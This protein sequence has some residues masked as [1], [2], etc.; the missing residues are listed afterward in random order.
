MPSSVLPAE[1]ANAELL[2]LLCPDLLV[3][4]SEPERRAVYWDISWGRY[5]ALDKKLG[6]N[7]PS[8]R[9]YYLNGEL[10]IM[11]T[12]KRHELLKKLIAGLLEIFFDHAGIEVVP[13]GQATMQEELKAA[14]AEPDESWSIGQEKQYADLVLEIALSS[15]GIPKLGIYQRFAI[16]EVWFRRRDHLEIFTL[17]PFG[18][19]EGSPQSK[20]LSSLD[21]AL[22]EHCVAI[23]S[24][25][26]ARRT[27]RKAL[28]VK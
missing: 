12:S 1:V 23:P 10:E 17:N 18:E 24:W 11:S 28:E 5:L 3:D 8:P 16:P 13:H 22:L 15:G 6:R 4:G 20:L 9:I 21:T 14:G 27:F 7:R 26:E 2:D 19:Y 25:Q